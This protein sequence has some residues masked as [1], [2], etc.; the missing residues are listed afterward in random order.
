VVAL[1]TAVYQVV[2]DGVIFSWTR[3]WLNLRETATL[4]KSRDKRLDTLII[5]WIIKPGT[6]KVQSVLR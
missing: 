4:T 2:L 1:Y 5:E 3:R 6:R